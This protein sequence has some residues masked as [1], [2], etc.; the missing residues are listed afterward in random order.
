MQRDVIG[1]G[2][3]L[4]ALR[5]FLGTVPSGG[6]A[7]VLAGEAGIGKTTLWQEALAEASDH[8]FLVLPSH[9]S[10]AESDLSLGAF[11]DLFED[12]RG[13]ALERLPAPQRHALDVALL[14]TESGDAPVD[15]R[16]L[17][18]A[19]INSAGNLLTS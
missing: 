9:P 6:A 8:G 3:E 2:S 19:A 5:E 16:T 14:R 13:E 7:L 17:S 10:A 11:A 1:R 4:A 12:V 18:F 15:Q